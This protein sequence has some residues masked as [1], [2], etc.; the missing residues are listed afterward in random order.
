MKLTYVMKEERQP[1]QILYRTFYKFSSLQI[2]KIN[3][4]SQREGHE[5]RHFFCSPVT[6]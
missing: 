2:V 5:L 1:S 3:I 4:S 6:F